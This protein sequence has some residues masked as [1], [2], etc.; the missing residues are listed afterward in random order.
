MTYDGVTNE[1]SENVEGI[2]PCQTALDNARNCC[3]QKYLKLIVPVTYE[4]F[5]VV[6]L[7]S[8]SKYPKL[9]IMV[10]KN[11]KKKEKKF[12]VNLCYIDKLLERRF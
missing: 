2:K 11:S 8:N 5:S 7:R 6:I 10:I 9:R 12:I 3:L 1:R 4:I